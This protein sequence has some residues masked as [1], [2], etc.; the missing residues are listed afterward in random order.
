M[1]PANL[2]CLHS[3]EEELIP[4]VIVAGSSTITAQFVIAVC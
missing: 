4:S 2:I 3:S 1:S